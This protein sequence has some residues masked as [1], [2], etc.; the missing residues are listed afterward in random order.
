MIP[1]NQHFNITCG[2]V[3]LIC[4]V[5]P[6]F[7]CLHAHPVSCSNFVTTIRSLLMNVVMYEQWTTFPS[8]KNRLEW[9]PSITDTIGTQHFVSYGEVSLTA[10]AW[11]RVKVALH[12][13]YVALCMHSVV[14]HLYD[15]W[16]VHIRWKS[17]HGRSKLLV[18]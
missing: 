4:V 18:V 1:N 11:C 13:T 16:A 14:W 10:C 3:L 8:E 5:L 6:P 2:N 9:N 15:G 12:H 7:S 17:V